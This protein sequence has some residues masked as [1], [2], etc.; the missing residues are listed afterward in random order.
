MKQEEYRSC[1]A[2]GLK[3]K[4]GL[5]KKE[6]QQLFCTQ[7]RLCSGKSK[8]EAEA[9][10]LCSIPTLPKWVKALIPKEQESCDV[11]KGRVMDDIDLINL[12]VKVGEADEAKEI[13]ARLIGGIYS[14]YNDKGILAFAD[15]IA[16]DFHDLSKRHY[17]KGESK[18]LVRK[19]DLL[20]ETLV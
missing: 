2:Q 4:T 18:E 10:A 16:A 5:S 19:F 15:E 12:K 17:L 3:G 20:K 6:R 9:E 8:T 11:C 14:C 1:M 7:S 13:V